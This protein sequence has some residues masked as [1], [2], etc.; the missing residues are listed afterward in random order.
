MHSNERFEISFRMKVFSN[1]AIVKFE[2]GEARKRKL[3]KEGTISNPGNN[4]MR[5]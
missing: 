3:Q 5:F 4:L 2:K 1:I